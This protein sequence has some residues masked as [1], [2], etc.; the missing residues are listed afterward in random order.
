MNHYFENT[1]THSYSQWEN[2]KKNTTKHS[3]KCGCNK[4]KCGGKEK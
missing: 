1:A 2:A 3:K 4:C